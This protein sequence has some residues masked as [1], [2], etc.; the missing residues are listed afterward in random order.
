MLL[1]AVVDGTDAGVADVGPSPG[2]RDRAYAFTELHVLPAA[3]RGGVGSAL[4]AAVSRWAAA[5]GYTGFEVFVS[6]ADPEGLRYAQVRGY[7]GVERYHD[8]ALDLPVPDPPP[9]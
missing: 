3:R 8:V 4:Y 7:E 9:H 5:R 6:D 2:G 1:L